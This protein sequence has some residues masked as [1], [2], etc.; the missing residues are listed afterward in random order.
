[1]TDPRRRLRRLD[2]IDV[3]NLWSRIEARATEPGSPAPLPRRGSTAQRLATIAVS[4]AIF[5]SGGIFLVSRFDESKPRP[6]PSD[7]RDVDTGAS[8]DDLRITCTDA[9]TIV[10]GD[11]AALR[12]DGVHIAFRDETDTDIVDIRDPQHPGHSMG[13]DLE[14][15][16]G[17][18]VLRS[19]GAGTWVAACLTVEGQ[20][21]LRDVPESAYSPPF[22]VID[23]HGFADDLRDASRCGTPLQD[24]IP[25]AGSE[26]PLAAQLDGWLMV[27]AWNGWSG[28]DRAFLVRAD[29]SGS[30]PIEAGDAEIEEAELSPDG[31]SF[32]LV[33]SDD[34][35]GDPTVS[36][37]SR[38]DREIYVMNRDGSELTRLTDNQASDDIV[39]WTPDGRLSFRS[40]RDS[41][42]SL[43][44]MDPDGS[45]V[46]PLVDLES[47]DSHDWAA[48]GLAFVGGDG[49]DR[50][51]GCRGNGVELHVANADGSGATA[52]TSDELYQQ[53]PAWSPDGST[54]A[55]TASNQ[56][57]Y[58]W[59]IFLVNPDGSDLR[60]IT[61]YDGYD[62]GPVWS[63]DGR[64]IAFTSD[65]YRGPDRQGESQEGLPYVMNADGSGVRPL[66]DPTDLGLESDWVIWVTDWLA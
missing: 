41:K 48:S 62:Q 22:D 58:A 50:G 66:L 4:F 63:P 42:L 17:T 56:S 38:E 46:H 59:E 8:D 60:R 20:L 13:F 36:D 45:N 5:L 35:D 12:A 15:D 40:N 47:A 37:A 57:D 10:E 26:A 1:M 19:L 31:S 39:H 32:A 27:H 25:T 43:Y 6:A 28:E 49:R 30:E 51:D 44:V 61:D 7:D 23:P 16:A 21:D 14:R 65:R 64:S 55:F 18:V 53:D 33:I 11:P 52:L 54:I 2:E 24:A 34:A 3:E 9:G 29:G